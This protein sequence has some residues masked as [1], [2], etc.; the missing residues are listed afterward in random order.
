[1]FSIYLYCQPSRYIFHS[2][3]H[4]LQFCRHLGQLACTQE[5]KRERERE[6]ERGKERETERE[7]VREIERDRERERKREKDP[8]TP[9]F[10]V[11]KLF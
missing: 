9:S 1:M 8:L 2:L 11:F 3:D 4:Y 10:A 5:R 7:R 6:R